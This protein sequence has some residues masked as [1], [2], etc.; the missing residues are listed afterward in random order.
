MIAFWTVAALLSAAAA[1][2]LL[3][4]AA[5][6]GADGPPADPA[7]TLYRRQLGEIGDLA[8]RG[9]LGADERKAAE[10]EAGRRLLAASASAETAWSET[11]HR[12]A[13]LLTAFAAPA[14]AMG[15]YVLLGAPGMADQPFAKRLKVWQGTPAELLPPAEIAALVGAQTRID[16]SNV[17]GFR[18]LA[19]AQTAAGQPGE[20]VRA[21]RRALK[22]APERADLWEMLGVALVEQAQGDLTTDARAAFTQNL[23]L[24]PDAPTARFYLAQAKINDGRTAEGLAEWKALLADLPADNPNREPLAAAIAEA[25]G[26]P[27]AQAAQPAMPTLDDIRGMVAGLAARIDAQPDDPEGWVRLVRAYAVL[28]DTRA[29][30]TAFAKA[31]A[32]YEGKPEILQAL[33]AAK[34]APPMQ[35]VGR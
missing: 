1:V 17:E 25:E 29:R 5:R 8:D 27:V 21:L 31:R 14:V 13:L 11:S 30:D 22:L 20:A 28:G 32:R 7:S 4:R 2:L 6:A 35:G 19:I 24:Q 23:K 16:P 15:L 10:A 3:S 34:A 26:A 9:L 18:F 12:K 33:D